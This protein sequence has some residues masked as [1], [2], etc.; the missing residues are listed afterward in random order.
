MSNFI[1]PIDDVLAKAE[2]SV[3]RP[4]LAEA[5]VEAG[6]VK[7]KQEAFER[8]IGDGNPGFV[9]HE[10]PTILDAVNAVRN[11]GGVTSLAHPIYYGVPVEELISCLVEHQID[12]VEAVHRS[13]GDAYRYELMKHAVAQ[14]LS[15][16]VGSD[17]HGMSYQ[18]H[19]GHMPVML[20]A[21]MG[22]IKGE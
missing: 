14:G 11:A 15:I 12:G 22:R 4:H 20:D 6:Y 16:T 21:L 18:Q 13:H 5:M 9:A 1:L 19:P 17:F 2:G 7:T 10:K 3:G 8:W